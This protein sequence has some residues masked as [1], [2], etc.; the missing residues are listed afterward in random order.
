MT[1]ES[2]SCRNKVFATV[3]VIILICSIL[4]YLE[5]IEIRLDRLQAIIAIHPVVTV[6]STTTQEDNTVWPSLID[7]KI[8]LEEIQMKLKRSKINAIRENAQCASVYS[9][10]RRAWRSLSNLSVD[11]RQEDFGSIDLASRCGAF[12]DDA[13]M[14]PS[15]W[16]LSPLEQDYLSFPQVNDIQDIASGN[17]SKIELITPLGINHTIK[18]GSEVKFKIILVN[19]RGEIRTLGGD[20]LNVRL[21]SLDINASIAADVIDNG[22]GTYTAVSCVPWS[23]DV[24]VI[25]EIAHHRE[26]FRLELYRQR[27]FKSTFWFV[28]NF[29]NGKVG[30][31]TPCLPFPHLPAH[32]SYELC[33]LTE[34]NGAPWYCGKPVKTR[35]LNCSHFV[36]TKRMNDFSYLPLSETEAQLSKIAGSVI[37]SDLVLNVLP[38]ETSNNTVITLPKLKCNERNLSLTFEYNNWFGFYYLNEWRPLT[39]IINTLIFYL[40]YQQVIYLGDS[41]ARA[42]YDQLTKIVRCQEK[43]YRNNAVWHAPLLCEDELN[44]ISIS[45]LPHTFPFIGTHGQELSK[46]HVF[47]ET[48]VLDSIPKEGKFIIYFHHF[49]HLNAFHLSV[50]EYRLILIREAAKRLLDRNP[51]VIILYQSA[52]Y[53]F[54]EHK[55]TRSGKFFVELQRR[56]LRGLGERVMFVN[57]WPMTIAVNNYINH[58]INAGDFTTLYTGHICGRL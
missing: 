35:F 34:V 48:K 8:T 24:E 45:Y 56:I 3:V 30:E 13:L 55:F 58:P 6:T 32:S 37:D 2:F 28:G 50:L 40:K 52:H 7:T 46:K 4:R 29:V 27:V 41:N 12:H 1:K 18:M 51:H 5:I 11:T 20:Q 16:P 54:Q 39:Y 53:A 31:A 23:G 44:N 57:T 26:T 19:A 38:D 47:S 36:S 42:Q 15:P 14:R 9:D 43:M 10:L 25:A 22:D 17:Y 21:V 33:N 49:M